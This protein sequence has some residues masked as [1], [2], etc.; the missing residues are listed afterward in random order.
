MATI[1]KVDLDQT[2]LY[3]LV[4]LRLTEQKIRKIIENRLAQGDS[5]ESVLE[6]FIEAARQQKDSDGLANL[7]SVVL[8]VENDQLEEALHASQETR[9]TWAEVSPVMRVVDGVIL[10]ALRR[11]DESFSAF[12]DSYQDFWAIL[13]S[14]EA[15]S[16]APSSLGQL[17]WE[18]LER[19][20]SRF[21]LP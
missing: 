18:S 20:Q 12:E 2:L 10:T 6:D 7:I 19:N 1:S 13:A 9:R 16:S 15:A 4:L 8:Y 11:Y 5:P 17:H 21:H 3:A 14:P